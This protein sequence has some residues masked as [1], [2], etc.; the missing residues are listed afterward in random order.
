MAGKLSHNHARPGGNEG[1]K[2]IAMTKKNKTWL[3][4][5]ISENG[6]NYA[7]AVPVSGS[8]NL[9]AVMGRISGLTAAH[10]CPSKK[11]ASELAAFW[12]DGYKA[13]GSYMFEVSK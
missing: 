13:N 2:E 5:T 3:A 7:Y 8:D 12:N 9:C 10:I 1:R 6:K 4:V 11:A